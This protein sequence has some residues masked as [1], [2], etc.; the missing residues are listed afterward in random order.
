MKQNKYLTVAAAVTMTLV[1]CGGKINKQ[2]AEVSTQQEIEQA[3]KQTVDIADASFSDGMTGN[4]F[5][6]Y[7]QVRTALV[8]SDADGKGGY[9]ISN[10]DEVR[11]PYFGGKMLKCGK[12]TETVTK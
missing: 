3:K 12:V 7:Q 4:V 1:S 5:H 6:N 9:W 11:N 10:V 2:E 8:N